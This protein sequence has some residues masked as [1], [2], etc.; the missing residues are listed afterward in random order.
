MRKIL[1]FI[2]YIPMLLLTSC[3]VHEWPE[4]IERVPFHLRLT[5][6]TDMSEWEHL[7]DGTSV[8]EQG[9][10]R[11]YKNHRDYGQIRYIVRAYPVSEKMRATSDYTQEFS[12]TKDISQGYDHEV[13]LD[14]PAGTYNIMIWSDLVHNS[15]DV[16]SYDA[17]NFAEIRLHGDHQGNTDYRDAFRGSNNI[18]L[19][20]DFVEHLPDTLDVTMQRPLAKFEF[21]TTDLQEFID[22]E[23]EFLKK[24][25]ET[26]GEDVP[27]R[28][29]T[30]KY[31]I[32][33][34]YAGFMPNTYNMNT[35]K[36]IDSSLGVFFESSLDVLNENEASLG[37]DYVFVNGKEA[38]VSIQI[39]LYDSKNRQMALSE[40]IDVPLRRS[41]HTLIKGSFLMQQASG[42]ITIK[43]EFDGNHNIVI[44]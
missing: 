30:D 11:T 31:K 5:Y 26:R 37:F 19:V 36:P 17:T 23:I 33:F 21:I 25:A 14:L 12:F 35:D 9:L 24:E 15:E 18:T 13:T 7:Y 6:N 43:P 16:H 40:P 29:D 2:L 1:F 22:K 10:G 27:T 4:M 39:G 8:I 28:V 41:Y 3:D 44:E 32:V 42:G 34:Q 20:A 38:G